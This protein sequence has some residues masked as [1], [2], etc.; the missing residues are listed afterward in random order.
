MKILVLCCILLLL[1]GCTISERMDEYA[2]EVELV[3]IRWVAR[4]LGLGWGTLE[5]RIGPVIADLWFPAYRLAVE[6]D[7]GTEDRPHLR[8][9]L[10]RYRTISEVSWLIFVTTGT[11]ERV[12][13]AVSVSRG[14]PAR[15]IGAQWQDLNSAY[16]LAYR[17]KLDKRR[18]IM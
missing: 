16:N 12:D 8:K 13:F 4:Q 2:H 18:K 7:L 5:H 3:L 15:C 6:V 14:G 11:Q 1:A 9:K 17:E 10:Q